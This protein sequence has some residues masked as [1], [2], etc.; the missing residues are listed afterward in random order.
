MQKILRNTI[1]VG[2][3]PSSCI[4]QCASRH[5][6]LEEDGVFSSLMSCFGNYFWCSGKMIMLLDMVQD[7]LPHCFS[8]DVIAL[9]DIRRY[10]SIWFNP[11]NAYVLRSR[12]HSCGKAGSAVRNHTDPTLLRILT[13]VQ[14]LL[15]AHEFFINCP[16]IIYTLV[17]LSNFELLHGQV[18][19]VN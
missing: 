8:R 13:H 12:L 7:V 1:E 10:I 11:V 15:L 18:W 19:T 6:F 2:L 4:A 9:C 17:I 16:I 3:A 5:S 14:S